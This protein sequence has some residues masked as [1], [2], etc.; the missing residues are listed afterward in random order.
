MQIIFSNTFI[1]KWNITKMTTIQDSIGSVHWLSSAF[2][3]KVKNLPT[4]Y[5]RLNSK[6][7]R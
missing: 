4:D 7:Y 5:L 2:Y 1:H 3:S 6:S